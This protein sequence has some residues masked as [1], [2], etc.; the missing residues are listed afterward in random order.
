[1]RTIQVTME[2]KLLEAFDEDEEVRRV[3][4]SAVLRRIARDYLAARGRAAVSERY[5]SAYGGKAD[6]VGVE[7]EGWEN[8]GAW[9]T[10]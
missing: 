9:P 1:M 10:E 6:E 3:G 4:R 8:E 2:E 5:R 7:L